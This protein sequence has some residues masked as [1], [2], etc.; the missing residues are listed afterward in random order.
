MPL[1]YFRPPWYECDNQFSRG[2]CRNILR[3]HNYAEKLVRIVHHF[4]LAD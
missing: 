1:T 3:L 4:G 2:N